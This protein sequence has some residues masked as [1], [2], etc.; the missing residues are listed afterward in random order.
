MKSKAAVVSSRLDSSEEV[1][2]T[3]DFTPERLVLTALKGVQT[4]HKYYTFLKT[5][6]NL[7]CMWM[8]SDVLEG[9]GAKSYDA[10]VHV[11]LLHHQ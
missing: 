4:C 9:T 3:V 2:F 8:T 11:A 10:L 7:G 6:N 1:L 5:P